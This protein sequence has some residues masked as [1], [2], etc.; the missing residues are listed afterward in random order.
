MLLLSIPLKG[1][2]GPRTQVPCPQVILCLCKTIVKRYA[3]TGFPV[4]GRVCF[5]SSCY[6]LF[7]WAGPGIVIEGALAK[8][9]IA[10]REVFCDDVPFPPFLGGGRGLLARCSS[11]NT[12]A[13][14]MEPKSKLTR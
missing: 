3:S 10:R 14:Y 9:A 2:R 11:G 13:I 8:D 5:K 7:M 6:A 1:H 4:Q 12:T